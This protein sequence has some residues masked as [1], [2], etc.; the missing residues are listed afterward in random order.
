MST[1]WWQP[2]P[3][4]RRASAGAKAVDLAHK[5]VEQGVDDVEAVARLRE[6]EGGQR[7]LQDAVRVIAQ[8]ADSGYPNSRIRRL[9]GAAAGRTRSRSD[10]C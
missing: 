4:V 8:H 2:V 9:L 1:S 7:A 10:R 6:V 5:L 3:S